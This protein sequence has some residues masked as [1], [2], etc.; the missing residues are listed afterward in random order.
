MRAH[1]G[2]LWAGLGAWTRLDGGNPKR[3]NHRTR[4]HIH[5]ESSPYPKVNRNTAPIPWG[6]DPTSSRTYEDYYYFY[7]PTRCFDCIDAPVRWW[8][9]L[10]RWT[11]GRRRWVWTHLAYPSGSAFYRP[12]WQQITQNEVPADAELRWALDGL[13]LKGFRIE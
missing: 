6:E 12:P 10:P 3:N 8:R 4:W 1:R 9:F 13:S 11:D 7:E 2:A 5:F